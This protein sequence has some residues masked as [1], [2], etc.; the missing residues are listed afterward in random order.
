MIW[1]AVG[2]ASQ[3]GKEWAGKRTALKVN[4]VD[5]CCVVSMYTVESR[6]ME[7]ENSKTKTRA[8]HVCGGGGGGA[9]L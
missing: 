9:S 1:P 7:S 2:K 8:S 3:G 4:T 6:K 5:W